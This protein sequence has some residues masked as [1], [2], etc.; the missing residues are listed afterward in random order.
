MGRFYWVAGLDK[1]GAPLMHLTPGAYAQKIY[2]LL[3][4]QVKCFADNG[5]DV[6]VDHVS[7]MDDYHLWRETLAGHQFVFCGVTAPEEILDQ[8]EKQRGDRVIEEAFI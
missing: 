1:N 2:K 6:I 5:V 3:M 7:L 8:G 4:A